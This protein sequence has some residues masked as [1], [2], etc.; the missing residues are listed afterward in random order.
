MSTRVYENF[1]LLVESGAAGTYR[2][3][4]TNSAVG[5]TSALDFALPF[6]DIELE[7]LL[8]KLDPGRMVSTRRIVDPYTQ[9][10]MDL[11]TGLF[12]A[13]FRDDV[14]LAWSR[15]L[16]A[17]RERNHGLRVRV[18]LAEV[19]TLA[20]LPWELLYD[21]RT[22]RFFAQSD[23]TPIVR[24]LDV[25]NPPRPLEVHGPLR[26]LVVI[27]SPRDL[28]TLEVEKEWAGIRDSLAEKVR[29]GLVV[30]DRL[31]SPTMSELQKWLRRNDVHVLHFVG[32]GTFDERSGEGVLAFCDQTNAT[33]PVSSAQLG[34]HVRDHDPLR[35]VVLNACQS[36]ATDNI[37]AYSGMAQGLVQQEASAVVAMQFPIS[38]SAAIVFTTEFYGS[39]ADGEP[40]D[41]AVTS[42]RKAMLS[43]FPREWA[44][45][46]L[47]LRAP[48]GRIFDRIERRRQAVAPPPPP[49][50]PP[51]AADDAV[52]RPIAERPPP[53]PVPA[54]VRR[55]T[56]APTAP[57]RPPDRRPPAPA[58]VP[59]RRETWVATAP[60]R[61]PARRPPDG[62]TG[63]G[64]AHSRAPK[65]GRRGRLAGVII[66]AIVLLA[67]GIAF[68][69]Q[70]RH[71]R[72]ASSSSSVA[73]SSRSETTSTS[74]GGTGGGQ[75]STSYPLLNGSNQSDSGQ[76]T[77]W[78]GPASAFGFKVERTFTLPAR[79]Q[80]VCSA[81]GQALGRHGDR[82][83]Y[84]TGD[85]WINDIFVDTH[86][87][88][89][90]VTPAC[91]GTAEIPSRG[92]TLPSEQTGPFQL[93]GGRSAPAYSEPESNDVVRTVA[94]DELVVVVCHRQGSEIRHEGRDGGTPSADWDQLA[95]GG[96]IPDAD[97]LTGKTDGS[98]PATTTC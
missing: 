42:G 2:A 6:S 31:P 94:K 11:G 78:R 55:E 96:W 16:D 68:A 89:A 5:D 82:L 79:V 84:Y 57:P 56:V 30:V 74:G 23:R 38:D 22:R 93:V 45:P 27:S 28:P 17:A 46:V 72:N 95:G 3:R 9:A 37:D 97:L 66:A 26:I 33:V 8:L 19:P 40:V 48:D 14:L 80:L 91:T 69:V 13:V 1:D 63:R 10:S 50:A 76:V 58:P 70:S 65:P 53:A 87:N 54:P 90:S 25:A 92:S 18:R 44:T 85:G 62:P 47:F 98:S 52:P 83:W 60:P 36:A 41:Q 32:H 71:L 61:P 35:L 15:S 67:G 77:A 20:G 88:K 64:P 75:S 86:G 7:N 81:Y 49:P 29:D 59:V 24:Y 4:V 12:D 51:P 34:A 73:T 43:D 21:R 39:L